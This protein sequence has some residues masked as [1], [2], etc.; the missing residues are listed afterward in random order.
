MAF[1]LIKSCSRRR[2]S[3]KQF[4]IKTYHR[5]LSLGPDLDHQFQIPS[6]NHR[7]YQHKDNT[8]DS[9]KKNLTLQFFNSLFQINSIRS[10]FKKQ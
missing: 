2:V 6:N 1:C 10:F 9:L 3:L 8:T 7:Q 4:F 5:S